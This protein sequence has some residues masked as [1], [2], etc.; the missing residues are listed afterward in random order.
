[1]ATDGAGNI[2]VTDTNSQTIRKVVLQ[3]GVVSTLA[4]TAG[5]SGSVDGTGAAARFNQPEGVAADGAG[6]LYVADSN[7]DTIRKIVMESGVV[8]TLAGAAGMPGS[9]DGTGAAARFQYPFGVA[10]DGTGN[11]YGADCDN[12]TI[13]NVTSVENSQKKISLFPSQKLGEKLA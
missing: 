7:N 2:Y 11:L 10:L 6:N 12:N 1:V 3:S 9:A 8:T 13:R 5:M 4:G